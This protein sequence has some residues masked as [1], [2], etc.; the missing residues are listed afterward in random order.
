MKTQTL[1]KTVTKNYAAGAENIVVTTLNNSSFGQVLVVTVAIVGI[2]SG[3]LLALLP[4]ASKWYGSLLIWCT[5]FLI[6]G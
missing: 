2:V 1:L 4:A 3:L 6:G 5:N